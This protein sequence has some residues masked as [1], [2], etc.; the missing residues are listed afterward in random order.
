MNREG[1]MRMLAELLEDVPVAERD[2]AIQYYNDYF[3]DAGVENEQNVIASLGSPEQLAKTIKTGLADGESVGEFTEKGF[4]A[5]EQKKSDEVLDI[6]RISETG[7]KYRSETDHDGNNS[8]QQGNGQS[9]NSGWQQEKSQTLNEEMF[10]KQSKKPS[11]GMIALIVILC[12]FA[13]PVLLGIAAGLFGII[14]GVLGGLFGIF[15][16][17]GGAAIGL[18]VAGVS[19]FGYGIVLMIG[20]PLS[21]LTMMGTGMVLAAFGLLFLWLTVIIYS[22]LIPVVIRGIVKLFHNIFHR[23]GVQA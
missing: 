20:V 15:I 5:Y 12:I 2:E 16:G 11:G 10:Q 22:M 21:G 17:I 6:S 23:G 4:S 18:I 1:F 19:L 13:S 8:W 14:V 7:G 9:K 3:D